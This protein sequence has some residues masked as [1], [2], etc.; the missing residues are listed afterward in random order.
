MTPRRPVREPVREPA[1]ERAVDLWEFLLREPGPE[2]PPVPRRDRLRAASYTVRGQRVL[3]R[4]GWPGAQRY[5]RG[6]RAAEQADGTRAAAQ[7]SLARREVIPCLTVLRLVTPDALCLPRSYALV[8]YLSALGLPAQV[9][10]A[11]QRTS[12]GGRFAFHAWAELYGEV[13]ADIPGVQSGFTVLQRVGAEGLSEHAPDPVRGPVRDPV[14]DHP[15]A[16]R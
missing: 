13:L 15:G 11:R 12:I 10:V 8:T 6:M 9:V 14:R 16:A 3:R 5:L 4:E 7:L 2:P 1:R